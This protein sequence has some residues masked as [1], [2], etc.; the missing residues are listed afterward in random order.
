VCSSDLD[1]VD[2]HA[3]R[4]TA[5]VAINLHTAFL[6]L[7]S[8]SVS[9]EGPGFDLGEAL[10]MHY[11]EITAGGREHGLL[12]VC[13]L[14]THLTTHKP[15][16]DGPWTNLVRCYVYELAP[17]E[18]V[19]LSYPSVIPVGIDYDMP[20][21]YWLGPE[22]HIGSD[23]LGAIRFAVEHGSAPLRDLLFRP[24][25]QLDGKYL[26]IEISGDI[27]PSQTVWF[28]DDDRPVRATS[29]PHVFL[30]ALE[31]VLPTHFAERRV[32]VL[33]TGSGDVGF[34]FTGWAAARDAPLFFAE[35]DCRAYLDGLA[36]GRVP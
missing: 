13:R 19:F 10:D 24:L 34:D 23:T 25:Q 11:R 20:E 33:R 1:N 21:T 9:D 16:D 27:S 14:A 32:V 3:P 18:S 31:E 7:I 15:Y 5:A 26:G 4:N 6:R 12:Q 35:A 2:R 17:R 30:T 28:R 29:K 22:A 8:I 36:A